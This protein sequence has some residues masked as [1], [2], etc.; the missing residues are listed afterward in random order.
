MKHAEEQCYKQKDTTTTKAT[1]ESEKKKI[2]NVA[3]VPVVAGMKD[4]VYKAVRASGA[5]STT[6]DSSCL[7]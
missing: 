3:A 6:Q 2:E 5:S 7:V 4:R 1:S